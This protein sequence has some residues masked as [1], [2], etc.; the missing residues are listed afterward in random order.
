MCLRRVEECPLKFM[1][2]QN[3][4]A[5]PYWEGSLQTWLRARM[6]SYWIRVG[7][8]SRQSPCKRQRRTQGATRRRRQKSVT[9]LQA[10]GCR[11]SLAATRRWE[12]P[13]AP[14]THTHRT[15]R[16]SGSRDTMILDFW[17]LEL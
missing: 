17:S 5:G 6:G 7:P 4:G 14:P 15:L 8:Q 16:G 3:L 12:R 1:F 13:G 11:G 2:L 9:C 10:K